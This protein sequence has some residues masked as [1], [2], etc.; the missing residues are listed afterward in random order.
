MQV[1]RRR[2]NLDQGNPKALLRAMATLSGVPRERSRGHP[3][4]ARKGVGCLL[5]GRDAERID[6]YVSVVSS[7]ACPPGNDGL[8]YVLLPRETG[9]RAEGPA[10]WTSEGPLITK[11]P[12]EEMLGARSVSRNRE[13]ELGLDRRETG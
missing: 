9:P 8:R 3:C 5:R 11:E 6:H 7:G 2:H 13:R 12:L 4:N 1:P 10:Y